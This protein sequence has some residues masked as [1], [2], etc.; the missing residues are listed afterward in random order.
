MDFRDIFASNLRRARHEKA[1]SQ[2]TLADVARINRTYVSK[3]ETGV[4][5]AGLEIIVKLAKVLDVEPADL[6]RRPAKRGRPRGG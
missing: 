2:E 1:M 5:W 3:L 6:L 4:T